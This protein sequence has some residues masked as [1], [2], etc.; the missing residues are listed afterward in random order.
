MGYAAPLGHCDDKV[1]Q[2]TCHVLVLDELPIIRSPL[3]LQELVLTDAVQIQ[4]DFS[5]SKVMFLHNPCALV[6]SVSWDSL[7]LILGIHCF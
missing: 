3:R 4:R 2:G 1:L 5:C 7:F 6:T